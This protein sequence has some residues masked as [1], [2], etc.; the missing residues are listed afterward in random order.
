M[1]INYK[2]PLFWLVQR[3]SIIFLSTLAQGYAEQV[4][5]NAD[6]GLRLE[7]G[8]QNLQGPNRTI[9]VTITNTSTAVANLAKCSLVILEKHGKPGRV[10]Y[11]NTASTIDEMTL[12]GSTYLAELVDTEA[13]NIKET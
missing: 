10:Y 1:R 3:V 11:S 4:Q 9:Q 13:L 12:P 8:S 2:L 7:V 6:P 5:H